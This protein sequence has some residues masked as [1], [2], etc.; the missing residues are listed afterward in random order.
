MASD[1]YDNL[2]GP[3]SRGVPSVG[4]SDRAARGNVMLAQAVAAVWCGL[5]WCWPSTVSQTRAFKVVNVSAN[6]QLPAS[7]PCPGKR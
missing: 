2:K 6:M 1:T 4:K 3:P 5:V 7:S